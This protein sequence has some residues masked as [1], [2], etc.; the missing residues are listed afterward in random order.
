[1][2]K[3]VLA[4]L[5][6]GFLISCS[7][8]EDQDKEKTV[9]I[10]IH[11][12][13][14]Y[15]QPV[16]DTTYY[17]HMLYSDTDNQSKRVF[18]GVSSEDFG[19]DYELGYEY[20][21]KAKKIRM[22]NPPQDVSDIKYQFIGPLHKRKAITED[23]EEVLNITVLP[24]FVSFYPLLS[25]KSDSIDPQVYDALLCTE[26]TNDRIFVLKEIEG[27]DFEEGNIYNLEVKRQIIADPYKEHFTLIDVVDKKSS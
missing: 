5:V 14:G 25:E 11:P 3:L 13:I 15:A 27:F 8:T 2:K 6:I 12:E 21:F 20:T 16:L 4:F 22:S 18:R 24:D 23:K 19:F 17:E 7:Q 9:E 1:M 26:E 10:T